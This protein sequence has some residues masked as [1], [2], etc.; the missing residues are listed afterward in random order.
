MNYC[1]L[2]KLPTHV[3]N[4]F[5]EELMKRK[6]SNLP[7]QWIQFDDFL[8]SEFLKIFENTELKIQWSKDKT[9]P[10]QK[11]FYSE[12]GHGFRIHKDG[13]KCQSALNIAISCNDTDWVRWYDDDYINSIGNISVLNTSN[14]TSRDIDIFDYENVEYI[15]ELHN[16]VGDV[17]TLDVNT[18]HS[19]KCIGEHPRLI[20][21]TKFEGFPNFEKITRS[22]SEK[23]FVNILKS[24]HC[25][26]EI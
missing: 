2:G 7:Y 20:I 26:K 14:K 3:V 4:F 17:Y 21:Q 22:L 25:T 19:F 1:L 18:Y 6:K 10:I 9:R 13:L 8:H 15:E 16:S 11:A 24:N 5:K 23:N 12:P